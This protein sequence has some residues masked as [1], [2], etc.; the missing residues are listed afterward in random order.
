MNKCP[1]L[2]HVF[3]TLTWNLSRDKS[4][5]I[6]TFTKVGAHEKLTGQMMTTAMHEAEV[7]ALYLIVTDFFLYFIKYIV[8]HRCDIAMK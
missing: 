6:L 2:F 5:K 8:C 3:Y 7:S 1:L 4:Y